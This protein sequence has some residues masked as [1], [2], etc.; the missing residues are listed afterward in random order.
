MSLYTALTIAFS[1]GYDDKALCLVMPRSQMKQWLLETAKT[2]EWDLCKNILL[3]FWVLEF[4]EQQQNLEKNKWKHWQSFLVSDPCNK[5]KFPEFSVFDSLLGRSRQHKSL[6]PYALSVLFAA[7]RRWCGPT[8][9]WTY[10]PQCQVLLS[11]CNALSACLCALF[12]SCFCLHLSMLSLCFICLC[13][14]PSLSKTLKGKVG[15]CV[16]KDWFNLRGFM[17]LSVRC[18]IIL[19]QSGFARY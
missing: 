15:E 17:S 1:C 6:G 7:N 3:H 16:P 12:F 19:G 4:N 5:W 8:A 14:P 2:S 11:T 18:S 10:L 9:P 13:F